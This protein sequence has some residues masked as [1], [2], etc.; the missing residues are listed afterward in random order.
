MSFDCKMIYNVTSKLL[1]WHT[2]QVN[3]EI[4]PSNSCYQNHVICIALE[5]IFYSDQSNCRFKCWAK[6]GRKFEFQCEYK[7]LKISNINCSLKGIRNGKFGKNVFGS[8][9]IV[10]A[11]NF[12]LFLLFATKCLRNLNLDTSHCYRD[13]AN[14]FVTTCLF[15]GLLCFRYILI[16]WM[17]I[18]LVSDL[19]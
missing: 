7:I 4:E 14:I 15:T 12:T 6:F 2:I 5:P 16:A 18:Q 13:L 9:D 11:K 8:Y 10:R 19:F 17:H 1:L 3:T